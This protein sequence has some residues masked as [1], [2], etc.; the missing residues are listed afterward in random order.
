MLSILLM[1]WST[2][3]CQRHSSG[4]FMHRRKLNNCLHPENFK[5]GKWR[6]RVAAPSHAS[7]LKHG[8]FGMKVA[9]SDSFALVLLEVHADL[10]HADLVQE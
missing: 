8:C 1:K 4:S 9:S 6:I 2:P 5:P 10:I 3:E 7:V